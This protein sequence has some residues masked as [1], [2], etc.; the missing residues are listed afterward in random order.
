MKWRAD[1]TR[2]IYISGG[3]TVGAVYPP[4][5]PGHRWK[6]RCWVNGKRTVSTGALSSN[7]LARR[8]VETVFANFLKSA[9]LVPAES[10]SA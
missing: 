1:E 8:A 3:M 7:H 4:S 9:G 2:E 5:R 10:D 6:W